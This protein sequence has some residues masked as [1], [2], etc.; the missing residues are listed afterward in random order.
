MQELKSKMDAFEVM[1]AEVREIEDKMGLSVLQAAQIVG[2]TTSGV[3]AHQKL[4]NALAPKVSF[5]HFSSSCFSPLY[6]ITMLT[7]VNILINCFNPQFVKL[8][9]QH[10]GW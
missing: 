6:W 9:A 2:M 10:I 7:A 1:K 4:V 8:Q 5:H 3:A